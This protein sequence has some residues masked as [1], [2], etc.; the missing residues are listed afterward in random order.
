MT[1][2][3]LKMFI[4]K[5][6]KDH[7]KYIKRR[8]AYDRQRIEVLKE[9]E[10][11]LE[12]KSRDVKIDVARSQKDELRRF[13]LEMGSRPG[14]SAVEGLL[15]LMENKALIFPRFARWVAFIVSVWD[16]RSWKGVL[17]ACTTLLLDFCGDDLT[18]GFYLMTTAAIRNLVK[19]LFTH[20][21]TITTEL[22][23][24]AS[25]SLDGTKEFINSMWDVINNPQFQTA[26][27]CFALWDVVSSLTV[28][29][30]LVSLGILPSYESA[31]KMMD[32]FGPALNIPSHV[33]LE[34]LIN[35]ATVSASGIYQLIKTRDPDILLGGANYLPW[36]NWASRLIDDTSLVTYEGK[37]IPNVI[38]PHERC[39]N[40]E[41]AMSAGEQCLRRMEKWKLPPHALTQVDI[42]LGR[43]RAKLSAEKSF[44]AN[45]HSRVTPFALMF[46]GASRIGKTEMAKEFHASLMNSVNYPWTPDTIYNLKSLKFWDG[47]TPV[48]TGIMMD[49]P[50]K[51]PAPPTME[52]AGHVSTFNAI[53][54]GAPMIA[55]MASLDDKGK[56]YIRPLAVYYCTNLENAGVKGKAMDISH[57]WGRVS[58]RIKVDLKPEFAFSEKDPRLDPDKM[59]PGADAWNFTVQRYEAHQSTDFERA[60]MADL[61]KTDSKQAVIEY[62]TSKFIKHYERENARIEGESNPTLCSKCG[63]PMSEHRLID[64]FLE[65][66]G[67]DR[68]WVCPKTVKLDI[69]GIDAKK[70]LQPKDVEVEKWRV[71]TQIRDQILEERN[72]LRRDEEFKQ[73]HG[74]IQETF[75][76]IHLRKE[77]KSAQFTSPLFGEIELQS[78]S[79]TFRRE[80][81]LYAPGSDLPDLTDESDDEIDGLPLPQ[82]QNN[83]NN[84]FSET[85][86]AHHMAVEHQM[87]VY[88]MKMSYLV[89]FVRKLSLFFIVVGF[90]CMLVNHTAAKV[91]GATILDLGLHGAI[92]EG[93]ITALRHVTINHF[94][95]HLLD[96]PA[97]PARW[98]PMKGLYY[99]IYL[100]VLCLRTPFLLKVYCNL[101]FHGHTI[102]G[103]LFNREMRELQL[104]S[105]SRTTL[106]RIWW[107]L[108]ERYKILVGFPLILSALFNFHLQLVFAIYFGSTLVYAI[109]WSN[110]MIHRAGLSKREAYVLLRI[111]W[112]NPR[113]SLSF[114]RFYYRIRFTG[115]SWIRALETASLETVFQERAMRYEMGAAAVSILAVILSVISLYVATNRTN[116]FLQH[117]VTDVPRPSL[118]NKGT[119]SKW[120]Q[121]GPD[122]YRANVLNPDPR[123]PASDVSTTVS[124]DQLCE[125]VAKG[126]GQ[127]T[128][129]TAPND[130]TVDMLHCRGSYF[131]TV[132]H[133]FAAAEEKDED[134]EA[135]TNIEWH[136][137]TR[138]R[139]HPNGKCRLYR[140]V[141]YFHVPGTDLCLFTI[142]GMFPAKGL[143]HFFPEDSQFGMQKDL[144]Q[145]LFIHR[146]RDGHANYPCDNIGTISMNFS[147]KKFG[148][149]QIP[150]R[151]MW[152]YVG[153]PSASGWCGSPIVLRRGGSAWIGGLHTSALTGELGFADEITQSMLRS[154]MELKIPRSRRPEW[155]V[156]ADLSQ[157][158]RDVKVEM[159]ELDPRSM[160]NG[161]S[162]LNTTLVGSV[163]SVNGKKP[164]RAKDKS[165]MRRTTFSEEFRDLATTWIGEDAY[166]A[167]HFDGIEVDGIFQ[168]PALHAIRQLETA[169]N[170]DRKELGQASTDYLTGLENLDG[171]ETF[172][173]LTEEEAIFGIPGGSIGAFDPKT[174][175]GYPWFRSKEFLYGRNKQTGEWHMHPQL[176]EQLNAIDATLKEGISPCPVVSWT[177][178]DEAVRASK[179]AQRRARVFMCYPFA[180]NLKLKQ[181]LGP[182]AAFMQ[183][184]KQFFECY[185]GMN[186]ASSEASEFRR[187]MT[188]FGEDSCVDGDMKWC[189]KGLDTEAFLEAIEIF[190]AVGAAIGYSDEQILIMRLLVLGFL[191]HIVWYKGDIM[192]LSHSNGSGS[193]I[194][195]LINSIYLSLLFRIYF[196]RGWLKNEQRPLVLFRTAVHLST[197]GDDNFSNICQ[198]LKWFSFRFIRDE[199]AKDMKSFVPGDKADGDYDWKPF[200]SCSFLKRRFVWSD[201]LRHWVARL[202]RASIARGLTIRKP[203]KISEKDQESAILLSASMEVF[204][205]GRE[206]YDVFTGRCREVCEKYKMSQKFKTYE[207]LRQTFGTEHFQTWARLDEVVLSWE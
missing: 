92:S 207:E 131:L 15:D 32:H 143:M 104:Q 206:E 155:F 79:S 16:A 89:R 116:I 33:F 65:K 78:Q 174:S 57:F 66:A 195:V 90:L 64:M 108:K 81:L 189:D 103:L 18:S 146:T 83:F 182:I 178:K 42:M 123:D 111:I 198:Q 138:S 101:Y 20:G 197:L 151:R 124:Y 56:L 52:H 25:G 142:S 128:C 133:A 88:A 24:Q 127:I 77:K 188:F 130:H 112:R 100:I 55:N 95:L 187:H 172:K 87:F 9:R 203:S 204:F 26:P 82:A 192:T 68:E 91:V 84:A 186:L 43:L 156:S 164:H 201:D 125:Q 175:A 165:Q 205:Y 28:A 93:T 23:Y 80:P 29:V 63:R 193:F 152:Q 173:V 58:Y 38:L 120:A 40:I 69:D 137:G 199:M 17:S 35:L 75:P 196:R 183:M 30:P 122:K 53:V 6:K 21:E 179:D 36:L 19:T 70:Y 49:D 47:Y 48:H 106:A 54:N 8:E 113:Q 148:D 41:L 27:I 169:Q 72:T 4:K 159:G 45:N 7:K 3:Q 99:F 119:L 71:R 184:H 114:L 177:L 105:L 162:S 115:I 163:E 97:P 31:K 136:F 34:K 170:L 94:H 5:N 37:K 62:M 110:S 153:V 67:Q 74:K 158:M 145:A 194:T 150:F 191:Y 11:E 96:R 149:Y 147:Q 10:R 190:S 157:G 73:W 46:L 200:G 154:V 176:R 118:I 161:A 117:S 168:H 107:R 160:L 140:D 44:L 144:D 1:R 59:Y 141:D 185:A 85:T 109:M 51:N 61:W 129:G 135:F 22:E 60:H 98:F 132:Y 180:F 171:R 12:L 181:Y 202:E 39:K 167:P 126:I 139:T 166:V 76:W 2:F 121:P 102:D 86:N 134:G 14:L 13:V 50:D